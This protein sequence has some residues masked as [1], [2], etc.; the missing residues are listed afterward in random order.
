L[1]SPTPDHYVPVLYTIVL[2]DK[3][4]E[5]SYFYDETGSLAAFS[6]LSFIL[7]G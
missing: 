3:Q 2:M 7:K 5:I 6:E 4:D 1:A